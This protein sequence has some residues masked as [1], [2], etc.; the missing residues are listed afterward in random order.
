MDSLGSGDGAG[1]H[2]GSLD[3]GTGGVRDSYNPSTGS[4]WQQAEYA[5]ET[6][7]EVREGR[8]PILRRVWI[9]IRRSIWGE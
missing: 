8:K 7:R 2:T 1:W 3:P 9:A 5:E 6:E 4:A